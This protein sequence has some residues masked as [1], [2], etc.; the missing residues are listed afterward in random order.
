MS[1]RKLYSIYC[2][3]AFIFDEDINFILFILTFGPHAPSCVFFP[4]WSRTKQLI[5]TLEVC[6]CVWSIPV[7]VQHGTGCGLEGRRCNKPE[8]VHWDVHL[9]QPQAQE[10]IMRPAVQEILWPSK[11]KQSPV[12]RWAVKLLSAIFL[13]RPR[14][15]AQGWK[16]TGPPLSPRCAEHLALEKHATL[17]EEMLSGPYSWRCPEAGQCLSPCAEAVWQDRV[18]PGSAGGTRLQAAHLFKL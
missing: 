16:K 2:T 4:A 3:N 17:G 6:V 8:S 5:Q 1:D 14:R 7:S 18:F 13:L 11:Q 12:S 15:C 10:S 9:C